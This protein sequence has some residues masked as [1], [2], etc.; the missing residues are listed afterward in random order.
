MMMLGA[1]L[2]TQTAGAASGAA[3][4]ATTMSAGIGGVGT[5]GELTLVGIL[6]LALV[7][8]A[9]AMVAGD[10]VRRREA[11]RRPAEWGDG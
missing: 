2:W 8:A 11:A 5:G 6:A 9:V 3:D 7:G 4:S 10:V 1:M